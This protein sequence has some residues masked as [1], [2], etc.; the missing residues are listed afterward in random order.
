MTFK[1]VESNS[2]LR[3]AFK[4]RRVVF[5]EEQGVSEDIEYDGFDHEALHMV[6]KEDDNIIGTARIRFLSEGQAKIER[7][8]LLKPFRK[9]GIGSGMMSEAVCPAGSLPLAR[10]S[11]YSLAWRRNSSS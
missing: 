7:M 8:A 10:Q 3:E 5:V 1:L 6:V 11:K 2:E 9:R 4:V